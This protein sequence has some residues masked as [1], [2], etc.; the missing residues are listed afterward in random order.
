MDSQIRDINIGLNEYMDVVNQIEKI[1]KKVNQENRLITSKESK[2]ELT[3]LI[4]LLE[5]KKSRVKIEEVENDSIHNFMVKNFSSYGKF[6]IAITKNNK[7]ECVIIDDL[8]VMFFISS[9]DGT[10]QIK[11][12]DLISGSFKHSLNILLDQKWYEERMNDLINELKESE[13]K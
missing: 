5:F 8:P 7:Y 12:N 6:Y 11:S 3:S 1:N 4:Q 2:K 9:V 13:K 10:R